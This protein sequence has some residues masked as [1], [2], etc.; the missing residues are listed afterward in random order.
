M[1][2]N[3]EQCR[4]AVAPDELA[5]LFTA[6]FNGGD[7]DALVALYEPSAL[8]FAGP[9]EPSRG[10]DQIAVSLRVMFDAEATIRLEQRRIRVV[11]DV[12]VISN[13]ATVT[14]GWDT[15]VTVTT[16]VARRQ[17]DGTWLYVLDDP[18]FSA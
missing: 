16:E 4:R 13:N 1:T 2:M 12:A 9:G 15:A 11:G 6:Y 10:R 17:V 18:F 3:D 8:F 14:T 5:E 7:L